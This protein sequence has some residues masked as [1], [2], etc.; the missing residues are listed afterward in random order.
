MIGVLDSSFDTNGSAGVG[1][2]GTEKN[3]EEK[4][5]TR[6]DNIYKLYTMR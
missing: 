2:K 4:L 5:Y 3:V 1:N 6:Q